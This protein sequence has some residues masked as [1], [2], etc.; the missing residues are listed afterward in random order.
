MLNTAIGTHQPTFP[1]NL[2]IEEKQYRT[3]PFTLM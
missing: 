2:S 1:M 3:D